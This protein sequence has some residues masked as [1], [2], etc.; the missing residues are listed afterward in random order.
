MK[1]L[2]LFEEYGRDLPDGVTYDDIDI[3]GYKI[4]LV[5]KP[6]NWEEVEESSIDLDD[7]SDDVLKALFKLP[8]YNVTDLNEV[9]DKPEKDEFLTDLEFKT[10]Y[11]ELYSGNITANNYI[12]FE[13]LKIPYQIFIIRFQM[14]NIDCGLLVDTQGFSYMRYVSL[15]KEFGDMYDYYKKDLELR[16]STPNS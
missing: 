2:K 15:I 5:K 1:Y 13:T 8:V 3:I 11:D 4:P 12:F 9:F 14:K 16:N 7:L 10:I 6:S